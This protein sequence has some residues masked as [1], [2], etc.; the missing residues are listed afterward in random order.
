MTSVLII[1]ELLSVTWQKVRILAVL[2]KTTFTAIDVLGGLGRLN[3][4]SVSVKRIRRLTQAINA[5]VLIGI[6]EILSELPTF[7]VISCLDALRRPTS[8]TSN[9]N[10][11]GRLT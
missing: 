11:F 4:A 7:T 3:S 8:P 9:V 6:H 1:R 2:M 10:R 5:M